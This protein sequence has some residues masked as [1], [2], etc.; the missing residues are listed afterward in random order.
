MSIQKPIA[1]IILNRNLPEPTNNL[2]LKVRPATTNGVSV[3][4][5]L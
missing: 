1:S 2:E 3:F 5:A 4:I